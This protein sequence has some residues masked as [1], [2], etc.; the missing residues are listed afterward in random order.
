LQSQKVAAGRHA[1]H[2]YILR[3]AQGI[4]Q[5]KRT[6]GVHVWQAA[7]ISG[8]SGPAQEEFFFQREA[9]KVVLIRTVFPY[10]VRYLS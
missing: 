9:T 2:G 3:P 5:L 10:A 4:I 1:M 6:D 8:E 7:T